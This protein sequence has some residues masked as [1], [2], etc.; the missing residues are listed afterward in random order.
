MIVFY[1]TRMYGKVDQVPGLFYVGTQFF[2][3]Q[4]VPLIPV[5]SYLVFEGSEKD[6]RF[7]GVKIGLSGKSVL[8]AY[9]RLAAFVGAA[10]TAVLAV[11]G[12]VRWGEGRAGWEEFVI[13]GVLAPLLGYIFYKTY[14]LAHASPERALRLAEQAGIPLE[15]VAQHFLTQDAAAVTGE[16]VTEAPAADAGPD[17]AGHHYAMTKENEP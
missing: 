14:G 5:G 9:G 2:Y 11:I 4:F 7:H 8:F 12:L 16:V 1:G 15:V 6:D 17:A 10:A 3:L 13:P